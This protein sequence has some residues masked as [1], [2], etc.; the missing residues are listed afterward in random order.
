MA[1]LPIILFEGVEDKSFLEELLEVL[2]L[3]EKF[4]FQKGDG[5]GKDG[6]EQILKGLVISTRKA[7]IIV[8]D[9]DG[10]PTGMCKNAQKQIGNAGFTIP[11]KPRETVETV[12]L[13]PLSVLMIPWDNDAGCLE[14]LCLSAK[15]SD[16]NKQ[17]DCADALVKCAGAEGW[18][19][20]K[21]SKLRMRGFLS[22]VCKSD[23]NT[24]LRY[25]WNRPEKPFP[26][27]GAAAYNQI[28]GYLSAF[29]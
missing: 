12:G 22:A 11:K 1:A 23:P 20:A 21:K 6:F 16:Y 27:K 26:L 2:G 29:A 18:D 13:P 15:N 24:G 28:A 19:I 4:D 25:A 14:T 7:I 5:A 9:N 3:R 10:D 8:A 17:L